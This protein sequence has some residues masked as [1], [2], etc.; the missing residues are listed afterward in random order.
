MWTILTSF[1]W[2]VWRRWRA[3]SRRTA[4]LCG[5]FWSVC[6]QFWPIQYDG[7]TE[8][9]KNSEEGHQIVC[10]QFWQF[11]MNGVE[12]LKGIVKK[13]PQIVFGQIWPV[14]WCGEAEGNCQVSLC[15]TPHQLLDGPFRGW[16]ELSRRTELFVDNFDQ[17]EMNGNCQEGPQ[18]LCGQFWPVSYEQ[19]GDAEGHC[20]EGPHIYVDNFDLYVNNFDQFNMTEVQKLKRIVK[21]VTKLYVDNFDSLRWMVWRRWRELSRNDRKLYLDKFDQFD[22]VERLKGIV[23]WVCV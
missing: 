10:G 21:K 14:W 22:G 11:E 15:L 7:S 23:K 17:F 6:E 20:Q 9:E 8:T 3:L 19:C 1:I 4:H 5:Q 2:T 18:I 12:T 16:R 13:R